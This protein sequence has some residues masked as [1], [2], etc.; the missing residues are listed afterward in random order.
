MKSN[1]TPSKSVGF[2]LLMS[3]V[4]EASAFIPPD[5]SEV[6]VDV[7]YALGSDGRWEYR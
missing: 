5:L 4:I 6:A 7:E 1:N 3:L 2:C